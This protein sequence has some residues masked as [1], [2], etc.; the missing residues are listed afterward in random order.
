[1][2]NS[3]DEVKNAWGFC[4]LLFSSLLRQMPNCQLYIAEILISNWIY[5]S[6]SLPLPACFS[7]SDDSPLRIT[8][9]SENVNS[10]LDNRVHSA[11]KQAMDGSEM[12]IT[13]IK[14]SHGLTP[15]EKK[16]L[17]AK[18]L[19]PLALSLLVLGGEVAIHFLIPLPSSREMMGLMANDTNRNSTHNFT[20][21]SPT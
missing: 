3:V 14:R 10:S 18:R 6:S 9:L 20:S 2:C 1:M 13:S 4:Y 11:E 19:I 16:T 12:G 17:I 15:S 8:L 5:K 7:K 21:E